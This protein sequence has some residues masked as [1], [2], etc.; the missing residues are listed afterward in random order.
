MQLKNI[1]LKNFKR[2]SDFQVQFSPKINVVKGSLNEIGKTTLL[3]GIITVLFYNPK[4]AAKLLQ[5]CVSWSSN[6]WYQTCLEFE[7]KGNRYLLVKDFE[8]GAINLTDHGT[9]EEFDTFKK[10]SE[11]MEELLGTKSDRLFSCT[12]CIRQDQVSEIS[13]G[14]KEISDSLEEVVTGGEENILA[15]EVIQ[16]LDNKIS[17]IKRGLDRPARFL[18]TL[19]NLKSKIGMVS[20]RLGEVK[21]EVSKVETQ[22]IELVEISKELAQVKEE[23][24]QASALLEKNKQRREIEASIKNL[25]KDYNEMDKLLWEINSLVAEAKRANEALRSIKGLESEQQVSEF[26][27]RLDTIQIRRED[28]GRDLDKREKEVTETKEKLNKRK[29][30]R[31][32]S[33]GKSIATAAIIFIGGIIGT[34]AGPSHLLSLIILGTAFL[35]TTI[36]ARSVLV[37][38]RTK[39]SGIEERIQRM[40]EVLGELGKEEKE[41]LAEAKSNTVSEFDEKE[42]DFNYWLKEKRKSEDQL[43]GK[44]GS[45]T[46]EE[47]EKQRGK[48]AKDL[49]VEQAKLTEDLKATV[50]SPEE[51]IKLEGKVGNLERKQAELEEQK[52][53]CETII[54]LARF[55]TE[56][57]IKLEEELE[58]LQEALQRE[59]YKVKVYELA[60]EFI[61]RAR[62][63]VFLSA[64][65][66]LEKEI[67]KHFVIFTNGKYDK[68][69]VGK[70]KLEFLVY[71]KEKSDWVKP[72]ELSGG[73]IDEF[74]LACRLALIKLIFGDKKPPLILDDPFGNFDP[75]RLAKTLDFFKKLAEDHQIII[76]TLKDL[77]DEVAD[78]IILL[79]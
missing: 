62:N 28:I 65:E 31:F 2:F 61:S 66:I 74:Y 73:V 39:I 22:K 50:L 49:A 33:S 14:K 57:Q 30:L 5:D 27:K 40:K 17:E 45:R 72:E 76:F 7:E 15:S 37:R 21:A 54:K 42:R 60:S 71:S 9:G 68:V 67:Q 24:E 64:T 48:L 69:K 55:D 77:Y 41:L 20:Q 34:L 78:N 59:E 10:V 1:K 12:S 26:R 70:E 23:Y 3:E 16:K 63:E 18:G 13:S 52:R 32:L 25:T 56:D 36:W 11:R 44:L 29:S 8:K 58:N 4:S 35:A 38:D 53:C 43:V 19:A 6:K 51:Y 79:D 46:T 47:I 75:V